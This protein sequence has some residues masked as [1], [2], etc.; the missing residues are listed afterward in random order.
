MLRVLLIAPETPGLQAG[1]NVRT[2]RIGD[3]PGVSVTS[4]IGTLVRHR[5]ASSHSYGA[6]RSTC[7]CGRVMAQTGICSCLTDRRR[8]RWLASEVRQAAI[9]TV[10][11]AVCDSTSA[12]LE[13]FVD[14]LPAAGINCVIMSIEVADTAAVAYDVALLQA[15][16]P[17]KHWERPHRHRGDWRSRRHDSTPAIPADNISQPAGTGRDH[18]RARDQWRQ[19]RSI[20]PG[21]IKFVTGWRLS[22]AT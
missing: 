10:V 19:R 1:A 13:G 12:R 20:G 4:V 7:C 11:L 17:A 18:P 3:V 22:S 16:A 8:S 15:L 5:C 21:N 2:T 9:K 6:G 14:V